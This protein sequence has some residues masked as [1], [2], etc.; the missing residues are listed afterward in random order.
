LGT[1]HPNPGDLRSTPARSLL[2]WNLEAALA[3]L[4]TC[5]LDVSK[6]KQPSLQFPLGWDVLCKQTTN[7]SM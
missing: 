6:Q 3:E 1:E 5:I 4:V 2:N 7:V